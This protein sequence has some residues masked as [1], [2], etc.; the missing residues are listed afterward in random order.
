M[1]KAIHPSLVIGLAL[2][3]TVFWGT[4][5]A[6]GEEGKAAEREMSRCEKTGDNDNKKMSESKGKPG[7]VLI[8]EGWF[9]MGSPVGTGNVDEYPQR[10]V[11]VD[12]F[13]IDKHEV[14]NKKYMEFC[15][16]TG[17][18]VPPNP[19]WDYEYFIAKRDHPVI[20][21]T[22]KN[23]DQYCRWKGKR[24]PTEAEWE[25]AARGGPEK[26]EYPWGNAFD[27]QKGNFDDEDKHDDRRVSGESG[28]DGFVE[29]AP[30]GSFEPNGAG[31]YDMAG[32]VWEWCSDW[33]GFYDS[34][35]IRN[36][37]GPPKGR[38][39]ALRGGSWYSPFDSSMRAA[40]RYRSAPAHSYHYV[41]FRCVETAD[42][43]SK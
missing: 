13:Y 35:A 33:Y 5:C 19:P 17:Q 6:V 34:S 12:A 2:S 37:Q 21:V 31:L 39:K 3:I 18:P 14:T 40:N 4:E 16:I 15:D 9:W 27:C 29:I 8:P 36:P 42:S 26:L 20:K 32:N 7:M 43:A 28:C 25:K 1:I 11:W 22:W 38:A 24:L 10:R 30:V 41:G 23:A